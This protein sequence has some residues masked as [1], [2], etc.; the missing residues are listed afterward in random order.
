MIHYLSEH[1]EIMVCGVCLAALLLDFLLGD[2]SWLT[3]PVV[4]IG[5]GISMMERDLRKIFPETPR[6][7][8]T[9]GAVMAVAIP[10]MTLVTVGVLLFL[11]YFVH[12][13]LWLAL[14]LLWCWQCLA[15]KGLRTESM[16][17]YQK[18]K[19][20][21]PDRPESIDEARQAVG[22]IVGR[23][24]AELSA[25]GVTK[26][27]V[28]TIAENYSDGV[29][30]PLFY[31]A[32]GGAPLAL[33]YKSINTMDSMVGYKNDRYLHFGRTAA[34]LDDVANYIPARLAAL[35]WIAA[36]AVTGFSA[37]GAWRIWRRDRRNHASPNSAQTE[38]ACA[39]SLGIQ[40]AGNAYYFGEL[41]EKPTIGDPER[42]IEA[43]DIRR[44]NRMMYAA[45]VMACLVFTGL[46]LLVCLLID[47]VI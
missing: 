26:A 5:R 1:P 38:S 20:V 39:G 40:L 47:G 46:R 28:E 25:E 12:V 32:I 45:S 9:A 19:A 21:D 16:N 17:V 44:T 33:V 41:Y 34:K 42:P 43:E 24:T 15:A 8:R 22:R 2:P 23:D 7:E 3:H 37:K 30:A 29:A 6:G 31:M 35:F 18:L 14:E 4:V 10:L 27:T 13:G 11:A 36:A